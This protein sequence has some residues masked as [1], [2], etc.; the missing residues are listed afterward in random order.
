[1][2]TAP[3]DGPI[4]R[5]RPKD[6][7]QRILTT[8]AELFRTD[9]YHAVSMSDIAERVGIVPSALYRHYR[10]KNELLVA[11][12]DEALSRYEEEI[13][14]VADPS[15]ATRR[16]VNV[17]TGSRALDSLWSRDQGH[18][19]PDERA[20]LLGRIRAVASGFAA[21]IDAAAAPGCVPAD[22]TSWAVFAVVNW[23]GHRE[24][25]IPVADQ[26]RMLTEAARAIVAAGLDPNRPA[27]EPMSVGP[28]QIDDSDR[29]LPASRR[30]A[31]LTTAITMFAV[32]GYPNVSLDDIGDAV[33]IAGPS[34]YNHFSSKRDILVC[35]IRRAFD[36]LWLELGR[37]L[38]QTT[39]PQIALDQLLAG[40]TRFAYAH[41]DL[42]A[43]CLSH[44]ALLDGDELASLTRTYLDYV[45]EWRRLVHMCRP[46]LTAD[47]AQTLVDLTLA[48][49]N[50]V[51][52]V[53][54]LR[55]PTLPDDARWLA[56][57]VVSAPLPPVD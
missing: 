31:L 8:A 45:G 25:P 28:A 35:G 6:R 20:L 33:G 21:L 56:A 32:R 24:L 52:R 23:P 41:W 17:T 38:G 57:A 5:A 44:T 12:F 29:M 53:E 19:H 18:L 22:V 51:V 3:A 16:I 30:E 1:M 55:M 40:Y 34:V 49:V 47:E 27:P 2:T 54:A 50:G 15:E 46:E 37:V 7:K 4:R 39:D 43:V 36:A 13:D 10:N 42:I 26:P 9:G 48:V 11:A 14:G